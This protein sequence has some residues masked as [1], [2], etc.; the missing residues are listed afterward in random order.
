MSDVIKGLIITVTDGITT[1][2]ATTVI[3]KIRKIDFK[4][5]ISYF[6]KFWQKIR[7][8]K[9]SISNQIREKI[10]GKEN[11]ELL[12]ELKI[13]KGNKLAIDFLADLNQGYKISGVD[14]LTTFINLYCYE[15]YI[16]DENYEEKY[17]EYIETNK[18]W[19]LDFKTYVLVELIKKY[20]K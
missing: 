4:K 16:S 13:L 7:G 14:I 10:I 2:L 5:L 18:A 3:K 15:I 8:I 6:D 20:S 9:D 17:K 19:N 11:L 1:H 12:K